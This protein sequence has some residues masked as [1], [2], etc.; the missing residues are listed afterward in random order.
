MQVQQGSSQHF[1][2]ALFPRLAGP[3]AAPVAPAAP[4]GDIFASFW[5][6]GL[7]LPPLEAPL[8]RC[9]PTSSSSRLH[10]A[11]IYAD[12]TDRC[13]GRGEAQ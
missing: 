10:I 12:C 2:K 4:P 5:K 7:R 6:A 11:L 1:F 9:K 8:T 3:P 13:D